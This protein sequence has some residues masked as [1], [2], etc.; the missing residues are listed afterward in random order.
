MLLFSPGV[1]VWVLVYPALVKRD[2][3]KEVW[4]KV[5]YG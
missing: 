4:K 5:P 2:I 3:K 1:M